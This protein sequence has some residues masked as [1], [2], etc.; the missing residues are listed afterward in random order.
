MFILI[1]RKEEAPRLALE[2]KCSSP[3]QV[4][5]LQGGRLFG[6][7]ELGAEARQIRKAEASG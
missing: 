3:V 4:L 5:A 7:R 2:A 6:R 1:N